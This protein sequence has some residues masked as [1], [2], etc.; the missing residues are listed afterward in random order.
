LIQNNGFHG[1]PDLIIEILSPSTA[2]Y[3]LAK[4]K[5][6]YE[7]FG[8]TEYWVVN[9]EDNTTTGFYR[10]QDDYQ[11]FF[12]GIGLIELKLLGWNCSF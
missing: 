5:A 9:P 11:A 10:V 7:R 12:K 3:D 8:V 6:V 2:T 1:A 4:K